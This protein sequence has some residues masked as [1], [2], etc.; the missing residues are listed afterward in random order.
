MDEITI[1]DE[2]KLPANGGT[3]MGS[4]YTATAEAK[5]AA[6]TILG[7]ATQINKRGEMLMHQDYLALSP[8]ER[9]R[10][11]MDCIKVL[12]PKNV[13]LDVVEKKITIE[14]KLKSLCGN[15]LN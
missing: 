11:N 12:T 15:I 14:A 2:E 6:Q 8:A 1:V 4:K 3:P 10:V 7:W 5:R 9:M 13:T